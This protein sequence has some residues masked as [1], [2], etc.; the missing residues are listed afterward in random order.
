MA[1][2]SRGEEGNSVMP[3]AVP[4]YLNK[5]EK[6][7]FSYMELIT[8]QGKNEHTSASTST[9]TSYILYLCIPGL[10]FVLMD[11]MCTMNVTREIR[12]PS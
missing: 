8:G 6:Q 7:L 11:G 9:P 4:Q 10:I 12:R 3:H 2:A 5:V 1:P